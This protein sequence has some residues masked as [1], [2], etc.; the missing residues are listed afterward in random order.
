MIVRPGFDSQRL[1]KILNN[2]DKFEYKI[3]VEY[4]SGLEY[5]LNNYGKEGWELS[6]VILQE[7]R[8]TLFLKRRYVIEIKN[9]H[10]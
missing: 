2:T 10:C 3:V 5:T 6:S 1:H 9:K 8:Y 7:T 4:Y